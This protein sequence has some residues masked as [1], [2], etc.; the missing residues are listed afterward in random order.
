MITFSLPLPITYNI[1]RWEILLLGYLCYFLHFY[2]IYSPVAW[3]DCAENYSKNDQRMPM[4]ISQ[5]F[6]VLKRDH[7]LSKDAQAQTAKTDK[8]ANLF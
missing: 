6:V 1:N 5:A 4:L 7:I 2:L 8:R 3:P